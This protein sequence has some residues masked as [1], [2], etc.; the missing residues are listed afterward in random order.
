MKVGFTTTMPVEIIYAAGHTPVDLNNIFITSA[1]VD[2]V[3]KAENRGFPRNTC[4]WI[5][6]IYTAVHEHGIDAIVAVTEGDCSNTRSLMSVFQEE[7]VRVIP[8]AF[9]IQ[10][11]RE[12]LQREIL[13]LTRAL[14]TDEQEVMRIKKE[15]DKIRSDLIYLDELTFDQ[16]KVTGKENHLWLVNSSD[17]NGNPEDYSHRLQK[18]LQEAV[19]RTRLSYQ[20]R[21][22][23]LGVPPIFEDLYDFL[24]ENGIHVVYNEIQRQFSMPYLEPDIV[25]Q[26]LHYTY[27]YTIFERLQDIKPELVRRNVDAV[28]SYS[29]AFCHRQIDNIVLRRHISIPILLLEGDKPG[30]LDARTKLRLESF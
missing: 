9:P 6:G 15:L 21:F 10:L 19:N 30:K 22:A 20:F 2:Y 23:F 1:A 27:P 28:I 24:M 13:Q 8:F 11:D 14:K 4:S 3:E 16:D 25:D 26:Y 17:F 18:F 7:N 29:Q 5:K 12:T